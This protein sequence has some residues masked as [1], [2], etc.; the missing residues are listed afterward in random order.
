MPASSSSE[1][2]ELTAGPCA[3]DGYWVT[4][5][6]GALVGP[7]GAGLPVPSGHTL[8]GSWGASGTVWS[9]GD[10]LHPTPER[11]SLRWF[12]YAED[13]FYQG[14]FAL[15]YAKILALLKQGT[16]DLEH[17]KRVPYNEFTVCVIP[18]GGVVVWLTGGNQVF[19]GRFQGEA[20]TPTAAEYARYYGA[21]DR[22]GMVEETREEMP[23]AVQAEIKAGNI[24]AKKWDDYLK[25]YPWQVAFNVPFTL[26][27]YSWHGVNAERISDPITRDGLAAYRQFLL[28]PVPKAIPS[29]LFLYGQ[30]EHGANYLVQVRAFDEQETMAAFQALH[31]AAPTSPITLEVILDKP[32]QKAT[33]TLRNDAR[34]VQLTK[35][36]TQIIGY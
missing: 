20:F 29:Q 21:V 19:L 18:Q 27:R 12:S 6:G 1:T 26:T 8:E 5:Q 7:G 15:P 28:S 11:L 30:A 24:K 3:A 13:K 25:T 34:E 4:I 36:A 16:W 33:L 9:S 14:D 22:A 17:E 32:L 2:F 10:D 31:T 23:P 35:S